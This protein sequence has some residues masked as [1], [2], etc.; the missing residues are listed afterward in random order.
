MDATMSQNTR[1][2][3]LEKMSRRYQ[4]GGPEHRKK[5]IDDAVELF[6]YH[7][8]SGIRRLAAKP[9][10][11]AEK[12]LRI[13]RPQ[14]YD[15]AWLLPALESIWLSGQ[16]PCGKRLAS[17]V[18]E[19]V[20][21]FEAYHRS[22]S[23]GVRERLA[24]ASAATLDRLLRPCRIEHGKGRS[25]T[26]PGTLLRQSIPIRGGSWEENQPGWTEADTVSLCGGLSMTAPV[27]VRLLSAPSR[28]ASSSST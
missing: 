14:K 6:G 8:K 19:W 4:N 16:Q 5:L 9:V 7:R 12:P 21:A 18:P 23:S 11:P 3:V 13:G 25:G 20:P 26:K 17:M 22:V 10:R 28:L 15:S 27:C 1:K 24:E 2:E